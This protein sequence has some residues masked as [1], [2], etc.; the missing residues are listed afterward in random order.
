MSSNVNPYNINGAYPIAGADN[1]SQGFRDNFTN[2]RTNLAFAKGEIED[3]QNKVVLK[4][5]L[6]GGTVDNN[7]NKELLTNAQ[8]AGFTEKSMPLGVTTTVNILF[9]DGHFQSVTTP[10]TGAGTLTVAFTDWPAAG[11]Y[12]KVRLQVDVKSVNYTL[13]LPP[14]VTTGPTEIAGC[15]LNVITFPAPGIYLFEFSSIDQANTAT[16]IAEVTH[17]LINAVSETFVENYVTA[18]INGVV[19][20]VSTSLDTLEEL[21]LAIGN[22][23]GFFS[24]VTSSITSINGEVALKANIA[25]LANVA[26]SGS[27]LDLSN[28]PVSAGTVLVGEVTGAAGDEVG[29]MKIDSTNLYVCIANHDGVTTIWKKITLADIV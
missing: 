8:I 13:T 26:T 11:Q 3:L 5:A 7:F 28:T 23:P 22:D 20:T 16:T 4:A 21:A 27:Y 6:E 12:A 24:N 19:G 9:A 18:A 14:E 15:V 25:D 1:D 2:I 10:I 29:D 17:K